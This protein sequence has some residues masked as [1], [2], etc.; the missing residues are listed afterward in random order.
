[1]RAFTSQTL[2]V[3]QFTI[4]NLLTCRERCNTLATSPSTTV[5]I[6]GL[7]PDSTMS[8]EPI[9]HLENSCVEPNDRVIGGCFIA[10]RHDLAVDPVDA[11]VRQAHIQIDAIQGGNN[12]SGQGL[13]GRRGGAAS[14]GMKSDCVL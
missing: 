10:I 11:V 3:S 8:M 13:N 4:R 2:P 1:M 12:G 14:E 6:F 5:N 9:C 7:T